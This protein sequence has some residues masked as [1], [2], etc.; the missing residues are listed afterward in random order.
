MSVI[1]VKIVTMYKILTAALFLLLMGHAAAQKGRIEGTITDSKTGETLP[2]ATILIEGTT[3]GAVADFDGK[4]TINNVEVGKVNLVASYIS[5]TS[6]KIAEVQVSATEPTQ[7]NVLLEPSTSKDL[8]TID[9]VVTLNKE[10]NTALVLQQKNSSAVTDG[11][12]AETIR[13]TPDRNTGDVLK[14]VSGVTIQDDKF[15]V[16][17]GLNERYNASYINNSPLPSTE[18]DRKAFAFDLFPAN[19]LDNLVIIKTATPDQPSEFAGGIIQVTTRS[20]PEKNFIALNTGSGYNT[21]T[22]GKTKIIYEGGKYDKLGF[23]DGSRNLPA[24]IPGI[25]E[26]STWITTPAQGAMAKNFKN[27][28]GYSE[29]TFAPNTNFQLSAGL[30]IK[31]KEQDFFGVLFSLG[32]YS[33]Q[34]LYSVNRAEY[35]E[36]SGKG[37]GGIRKPIESEYTNVV[38]QSQRATGSLLNFSLKPNSNTSISIKNLFSGLTDDK[39]ITIKG[40]NNYNE[41]NIIRDKINVRYFS[42]NRI[43]SSQL[44]SEHY[45]PDAKIKINFNLGFSSVQRTVP[46]MR[47]SAYGRY[48]RLNPFDPS[49]GPNVRDTLYKAYVGQ[50]PS[51]GPDYAGFRVYSAL[52]EKLAGSRLDVSKDFRISED[53]KINVKAG[54]FYQQR[55]R[56][57]NMRRFGLSQYSSFQGTAVVFDD[58]L[59]YVGEDQIFSQQNMGVTSYGR[60]GFKLIEDSKPDDNYFATSHLYAGYLMGDFKLTDKWRII[61]GARYESY[62]QK[63]SVD[64]N[65]FDSI[66]VQNTVNDLLPSL[67]LV[68]NL[69]EK[70]ALRFAWYKTLNRAEFRELAA[71]NWYDPETR[72]SIA[73]N[74]DLQRAAIQNFDLRYEAYPGRGQLLTISGF[75]KY[76]NSPIERYMYQGSTIQVYF[77]NANFAHVYG[78]ELEYRV[79]LGAILK[80]DS[81][82]F[83]NNLNVFSNLSLIKSLVNVAGIDENVADTRAMQGQAP[84]I[85]NG[86]ISY[87]DTKN[88][89]SITGMINRVGTSI[90]VVGN[91]QVLNRYVKPR[92]VIDLQ[93]T[94]SFFK[95]KLDLRLNVRDLLHQDLVYYYKSDESRKKNTYQEGD[96]LNIVRNYGSTFSFAAGYKF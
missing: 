80:K 32:Y 17:R 61:T 49:E 87:V 38:N 83:L 68:Y 51:T 95:N 62:A 50:T 81:V 84:Y 21:I 13:K 79:N 57:F 42:A 85:I 43:L 52:N 12:S 46:N 73:G 60:G 48:D 92:T 7:V 11:I 6:K 58:S 66:Y 34:S 27:D 19:M 47:F 2:G 10:N 23:D 96:Y 65:T 89:Y 76:F 41:E 86:G 71:A 22:T 28:W 88:N 59:L 31:R 15:V 18:P 5:Y 45:L 33:T 77:K 29:S 39:F 91:S 64:Y 25:H 44:N 16:V 53:T 74:P 26:K 93:L 30:N 24:A 56:Q 8:Q 94:K 78:S 14:R 72:L 70:S 63:L 20:I 9:V 90:Y 69:A 67:N 54:V 82:P 1:C 3:K 37:D 4:F 75:Y 35:E 36:L 55:S 40:T